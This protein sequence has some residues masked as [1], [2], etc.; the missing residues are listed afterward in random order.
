MKAMTDLHRSLAANLKTL[1]ARWGFSQAG[2]AERSD[3]SVS[4]VG[5]IE[6]GLKWP[7]AD[8]LERLSKALHIEPY[9]LFLSPSDTLSLQAW[10][11]RR[12]QIVELGE[13]LIAYFEKRHQ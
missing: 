1:R 7:Q 10:L 4:Y 9:Q 3:V 6:M 2:L 5:E 13:D 12:D 11:E 8:V